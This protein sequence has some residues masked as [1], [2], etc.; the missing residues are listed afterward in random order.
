MN[1]IHAGQIKGMYI[2]GREPAM[3]DPD[4][5]HAREALAQARSSRGAGSLSSPRP[6][7]HA[8]VILPASAFAEKDGS[9]H[10]HRP[11]RAARAPGDQAA[12]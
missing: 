10:Q 3:S 1:A 4:L 12:R 11:P 5:Q 9:F 8:D 2:E 6:R 7:F